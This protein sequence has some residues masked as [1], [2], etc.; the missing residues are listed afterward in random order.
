MSKEN[1]GKKFD[2]CL[3]NPPY[4]RSLHLDF[5]EK[6]I[7]LCD[8]TVIVEPGQWLVQLKE[9]GIYTKENSKSKKIQNKIEGHVKYVELNNYNKELNIANKMVC[10]IVYV[11]FTK[12]YNEIDFECITEK[13][14]VKCLSDCNL[15]GERKIVDDILNK[16]KSYEDH[17]IDHVIDTK[18][19]KEYE[20][21]G[22][23]FLPYG[24]YMLNNLGTTKTNKWTSGFHTK[25][26][27]I[28]TLNSYF[29]VSCTRHKERLSTKVY[30]GTRSN[31]P[32]DSVYGTKEQMEN[33]YYFVYNN[34]LPL[35]V[36]I[37]LTIDEQNNSRE[38]VPW[39]VDKKYT[40]EEIYEKLNITKEEQKLIDATIKKFDKDT[41]F[42]RKLFGVEQL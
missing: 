15:I 32:F 22:Y 37:C 13:S 30:I 12:K 24:K 29:E 27:L 23:W 20:S 2:I 4:D 11:D 42:G 25:N 18:K 7:E 26:D 17:M 14:K 38:Y 28:D 16:C 31:N 19:Y 40:D 10:S 41:A 34:K 36:N 6:S 39:L 35:F 9:N 5:L 1:K 8:K 33:W 21:K 3:M